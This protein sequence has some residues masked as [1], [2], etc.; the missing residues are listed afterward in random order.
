MR[1][2]G[3]HRNSTFKLQVKVEGDDVVLKADKESL[4]NSHRSPIACGSKPDQDSRVFLI[5]GGG[6]CVTLFAYIM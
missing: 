4:A 3:N 1:K 5:V 2:L 6:G